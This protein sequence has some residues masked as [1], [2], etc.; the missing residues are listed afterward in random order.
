MIFKFKNLFFLVF[1]LLIA[2]CFPQEER[3]SLT[4]KERKILDSLYA[5]ELKSLKKSLHEECLSLQDSLYPK[6]VDSILELRLI[7]VEQIIND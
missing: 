4:K 6:Y 1:V 3:T 2:S 7:E 5:V